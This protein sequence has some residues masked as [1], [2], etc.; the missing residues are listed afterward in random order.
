M[1]PLLAR[2]R[3]P[4]AA[5]GNEIN[6]P[7]ME[8]RRATRADVPAV[9]DL[10]RLLAEFERLP[11]PDG[12]A[13]ER[14]ARDAFDHDP[15]RIELWVADDGGRVVAYAACFASYSTFRARP[16]LFLEDLFVHPAARRRGIARR[17]LAYLRAEAERRG[18]GRFEWMVLG[19][20]QDAIALYREIGA[21]L[22][23]DWQLYR[24]D[25]TGRSTPPP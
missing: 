6:P 18:C 23:G 8:I 21:E 19:W 11:P 12:E 17:F 25:L 13:G 15:P 22:Q 24:I 1:R 9:V 10:I 16:S 14:L 7:F 2:H 3:C 5:G 4:T 20:N